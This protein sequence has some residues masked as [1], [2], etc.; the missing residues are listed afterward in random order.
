MNARGKSTRLRKTPRMER[1]GG[2]T[3]E[4]CWEI[5]AKDEWEPGSSCEAESFGDSFKRKE[6]ELRRGTTELTEG[7]D[8]FKRK[9]GELRTIGENI[10]K[11]LLCNSRPTTNII[12]HSNTENHKNAVREVEKRKQ[13]EGESS[14]YNWA[15]VN[16]YNQMNTEHSECEN[17]RGEASIIFNDPSESEAETEPDAH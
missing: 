7:E 10:W 16:K 9:E 12:K 11:C 4:T 8:S 17:H 6:G 3:M 13:H 15:G 2:K 14:S 5:E 1:K